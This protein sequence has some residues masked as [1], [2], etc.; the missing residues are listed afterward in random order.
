[1]SLMDHGTTYL[2]CDIVTFVRPVED[3]YF[4]IRIMVSMLFAL[5]N[6][7]MRNVHVEAEESFQS[8]TKKNQINVMKLISKENIGSIRVIINDDAKIRL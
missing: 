8:A 7:Q 1:M 6:F 5:I 3:C 4:I 2:C